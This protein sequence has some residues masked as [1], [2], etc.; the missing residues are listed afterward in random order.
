MIYHM[1]E[2]PL[3]RQC[4]A[5]GASGAD[6][7]IA[8]R[9]GTLRPLNRFRAVIMIESLSLLQKR[10]SRTRSRS[11][12]G[13]FGLI[14]A[15]LGCGTLRTRL[16]QSS[17][18]LRLLVILS[19]RQRMSLKHPSWQQQLNAIENIVGLRKHGWIGV[20]LQL[21]LEAVR[22]LEKVAVKCLTQGR[23]GA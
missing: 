6:A 21:H 15:S 5:P 12:S 3:A 9:H 13:R 18:W 7:H 11:E 8:L 10:R 4:M 20:N 22:Q 14:G 17:S 16:S 2:R 19:S 23:L 1:R